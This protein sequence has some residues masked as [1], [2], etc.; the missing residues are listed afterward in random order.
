M[1]IA[2]PAAELK[3]A[4][5]GRRPIEKT[6]FFFVAMVESLLSDLTRVVGDECRRGCERAV[7]VGERAGRVELLLDLLQLAR[8]EG[9][10]VGAE[11]EDGE[12]LTGAVR[13]PAVRPVGVELRREAEHVGERALEVR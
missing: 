12:L 10:G 1:N 4:R 6:L 3:P 2:A 13:H 5:N 11:R 9:V 8:V 7:E